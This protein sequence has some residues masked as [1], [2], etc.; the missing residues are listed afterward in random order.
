MNASII[1]AIKVAMLT[2][3]IAVIGTLWLANL[4][5]T[6]PVEAAFTPPVACLEDGMAV[7]AA[8]AAGGSSG[9]GAQPYSY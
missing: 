5:K 2:G 1:N 6:E 8:V 9:E 3:L 7:N 4:G